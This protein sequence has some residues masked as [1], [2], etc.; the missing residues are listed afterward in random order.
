MVFNGFVLE[1]MEPFLR[2][3]DSIHHG[4]EIARKCGLNQKTVANTLNRLGEEG[5]LKSR[6]VGKNKEFS[7]SFDDPE[8]TIRF[9]LSLEN[10][11]TLKFL[12][13]NPKVKEIL[14]KAKPYFKGVVVVFGSYAKGIQKKDSDLDVLSVGG[15]DSKKVKEISDMYGVEV[16]VKGMDLSGFRQSLRERDIF[17]KEVV[18]DHIIVFGMEDFL[19]DVLR[20]YYGR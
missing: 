15:Y 12:E 14:S 10:S 19:E 18:S 13:A 20:E 11:R 2:D 17:M 6:T 3:L 5:V 7:V 9:L 16:S 4:S 1:V 8:K